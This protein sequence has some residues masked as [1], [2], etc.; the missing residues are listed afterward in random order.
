MEE[1]PTISRDHRL[2]R[3]LGRGGMGVVYEAE[4][5]KLGRRVALKV[6]SEERSD[7]A[8]ALA[9]LR[10]EALSMGALQHPHIVQVSD[11][12]EGPPPFLEMEL[13]A[14]QS[15]RDRLAERGAMSA[16]DACSVALQLLSALGAAHRAGIIH[17]DVKPA[18]V[19]V[20]ETPLTDVFVKLLDFGVAKLLT[21]QQGP[22]LT[23][24]D[25]VV[26]SAPYM[27]PEQIRGEAIDG[28]TDLFA[29]GVTLYEMLA[30]QRP[31]VA[32]PNEN[33]MATI[34]RGGPIA[35]L[36]GVPG[37]L[38]AAVLRALTPSPSVRWTSA[39]EMTAALLPFVSR[40]QLNALATSATAIRAPASVTS[41][42]TRTAEAALW[43][44]PTI[45]RTIDQTAG[46]IDQTAG[47]SSPA[48]TTP[49]VPP[50]PW[51]S[52]HRPSLAHPSPAAYAPRPARSLA[53][54]LIG[55]GA[56]LALVLFVVGL[57]V[58]AW[59][60]GV[61]PDSLT[62]AP[63]PTPPPLSTATI[64]PVVGSCKSSGFCFETTSFFTPKD[65]PA[66]CTKDRGSTWRDGP[67]DRSGSFGGCRHA[68][69][70]LTIW[71]YPP[72]EKKKTEHCPNDGVPVLP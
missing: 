18:N 26:G 53:P 10:R 67:C 19:F 57:G 15:L 63:A 9:R 3:V 11:F 54:F 49:T 7:D 41:V 68:N 29:L 8:T 25:A 17:R 4:H 42:G 50:P 60:S 70:G 39:E 48:P 38:E 37:A 56:M 55:G 69:G 6:L 44:P 30:G 5:L 35:P 65:A 52:E 45:S 34:L 51:P 66:K 12:N 46:T 33:V 72:S 31:F 36:A 21:P 14:G 13:L 16:A 58:L 64:G 40:E 2:L 28:R 61:T 32:A 27:A 23:S 47:F 20:V 62:P 59:T 71:Y 1:L 24:F 22:A 43:G